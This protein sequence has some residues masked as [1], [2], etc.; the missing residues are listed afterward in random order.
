M[1]SKHIQEIILRSLGSVAAGTGV[2][3][4]QLLALCNAEALHELSPEAVGHE[5]AE[6]VD[7]GHVGIAWDAAVAVTAWR[8][9][10]PREHYRITNMLNAWSVDR[11]DLEVPGRWRTV[12]MGTESEARVCMTALNIFHTKLSNQIAR[13]K[14][15]A[16]ELASQRKKPNTTEAT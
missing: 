8:Y 3:C 5:L 6:L 4:V 14:T 12:V 7:R 11:A 10:I 13:F 1:N 9:R 15:R 2:T 16:D